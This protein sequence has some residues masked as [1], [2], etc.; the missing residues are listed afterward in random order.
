MPETPIALNVPDTCAH[1]GVAGRVQL[2]QTIHGQRVLLEWACQSCGRE[3]LV[4]H[5]DEHPEKPYQ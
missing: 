1:C 5:K 3:W 4:R 2:Q